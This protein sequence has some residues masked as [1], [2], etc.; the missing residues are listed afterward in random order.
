MSI[1]L[2]RKEYIKFCMGQSEGGRDALLDDDTKFETKSLTR[3][4]SNIEDLSTN[5]DIKFFIY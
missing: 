4:P 2:K 5:L 3:G 1:S